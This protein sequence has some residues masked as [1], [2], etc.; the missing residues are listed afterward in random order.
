MY[1]LRSLHEIACKGVR[2]YFANCDKFKKNEI[3]VWMIPFRKQFYSL[4][5]QVYSKLTCQDY[6]VMVYWTTIV[7]TVVSLAMSLYEFYFVSN[8]KYLLQPKSFMNRTYSRIPPHIRRNGRVFG[9]IYSM[10]SLTLLLVGLIKFKTIYMEFW[11]HSYSVVLALEI[12]YWMYGL[13]FKR[14]LNWRPLLCI[15]LLLLRWSAAYYMKQ[16]IEGAI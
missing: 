9:L 6:F 10:I 12:V 2:L 15:F 5:D 7:L 3:N 4:S 8:E 14:R 1:K 16:I 13:I 11:I